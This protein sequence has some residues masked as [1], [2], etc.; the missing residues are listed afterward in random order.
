MPLDLE[1]PRERLEYLMQD[2]GIALLLTESQAL[3]ERL[4]LPAGVQ[5]L[6]LDGLDLSSEDSDLPVV[7]LEPDNLAYVIYTSGSTGMPKG[8]AV[9]PMVRWRCTS[10]RPSASATRCP[11]PTASCTS[12]R[13]PSTAPTSAG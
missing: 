10:T 2:A 4:P 8:V 12:C 6:E 3:R 5:C 13:S 7:A 11:R 1:Y 9:S